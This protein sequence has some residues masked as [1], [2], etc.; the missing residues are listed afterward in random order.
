MKP[1]QISV[2]FFSTIVVTT[3]YTQN[4]YYHHLYLLLVIF[5]ILNHQLDRDKDNSRNIIHVIDT[6]LAHLA[7][8]STLYDSYTEPFMCISLLNTFMFY[9]F[10]YIYPRYAELFHMM[11]HYHTV[12]SMNIYFIYIL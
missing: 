2:S 5:G 7:F 11:I 4:S 9:I 6:F 8:V 12:L 3:Y 1:L 10:E